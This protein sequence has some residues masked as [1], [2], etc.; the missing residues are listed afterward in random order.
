[1]LR[2]GSAAYNETIQ[3]LKSGQHFGVSEL[4]IK[5]WQFAVKRGAKINN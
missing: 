1:M 5:F 2:K 4:T 3:T